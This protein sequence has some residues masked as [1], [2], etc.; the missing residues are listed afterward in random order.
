MNGPD[1]VGALDKAAKACAD[2]IS[3]LANPEHSLGTTDAAALSA[4]AECLAAIGSL[5]ERYVGKPKGF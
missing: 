1:V 4:L 2:T 3:D 5:R